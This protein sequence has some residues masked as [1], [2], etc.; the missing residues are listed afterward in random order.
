MSRAV[1]ICEVVRRRPATTPFLSYQPFVWIRFIIQRRQAS[2]TSLAPSSAPPSFDFNA[3]LS[4]SLESSQ[5][6]SVHSNS[7][8]RPRRFNL[9]KLFKMRPYEVLPLV[10]PNPPVLRSESLAY[11]TPTHKTLV[12]RFSYCVRRHSNA[13]LATLGFVAFLLVI[14]SDFLHDTFPSTRGSGY[15]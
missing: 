2:H 1:F 5:H 6:L 9:T 14:T 13:V 11:P 8:S 15:V 10:N 12:A 4:G 7:S 3:T